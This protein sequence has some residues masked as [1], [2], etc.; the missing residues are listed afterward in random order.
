MPFPAMR[1]TPVARS[2]LGSTPAT[3]AIPVRLRLGSVGTCN[4]EEEVRMLAALNMGVLGTIL[5]VVLVIA[6]IMWFVRRA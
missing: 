6:A 5:L 1:A 2:S 4:P 3:A